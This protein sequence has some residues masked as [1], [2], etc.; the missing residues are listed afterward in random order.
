[1]TVKNVS[2]AALVPIL[3]P[4]LPQ[5]VHLAALPPNHLIVMDQYG[6]VKRITAIVK[7]LDQ[8]GA[9]APPKD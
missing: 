2:S 4:L 7:A 9:G 6:N 1:V 5:S 8:P 3:R